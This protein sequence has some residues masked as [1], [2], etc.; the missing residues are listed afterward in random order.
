MTNKW[1]FYQLLNSC[2]NPRAMYA[3][4]G[5]L[6]NDKLRKERITPYDH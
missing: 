2:Q 1:K 3:A 4:L 5:A 6:V